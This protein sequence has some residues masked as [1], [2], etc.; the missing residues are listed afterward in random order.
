MALKGVGTWQSSRRGESVVTLPEY[1]Y[2]KGTKDFTGRPRDG[3]YLR[4]LGGVKGQPVSS[5]GEEQLLGN[6]GPEHPYYPYRGLVA[7]HEFAHGIQNLCF[8][9]EDWTEWTGFYNAARE[10]NVFPGSHMM[11]DR[12]EF[13]AVLTTVYFEVTSELGRGL[14]RES[15]TSIVPQGKDVLAAL[16]EIYDGAVL[17]EEFRE[18]L[19]D[20]RWLKSNNPTLYRQIQ[21]LPWVADGLT[22]SGARQPSYGMQ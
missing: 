22:D 2:L 10:A 14:T 8:T 19:W 12:M 18:R 6:R 5:A 15:M 17:P 1:R 9:S 4:G 21:E 11:H 3:F 13:F 16:E 7:V 20:T